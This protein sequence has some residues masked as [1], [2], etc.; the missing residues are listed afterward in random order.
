M[1]VS[2]LIVD[3]HEGVRAGIRLL[4]G[5]D[6]RW[7]VCGE[8][9]SGLDAIEKSKKLNPDV[10]LMDISMPRMDGLSATRIIRKEFPSIRVLIVTQNDPAVSLL[11]ARDVG[12]EGF[13]GK[14]NL[15]NDL[16]PTLENMLAA[17]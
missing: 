2:I 8:A 4:L 11:Q 6:R 12:A 7:V 9:V 15:S 1:S 17:R 13:V 3:D 14:L 10:I 5:K 16:I